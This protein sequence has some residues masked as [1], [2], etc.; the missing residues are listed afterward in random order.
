MTREE[1]LVQALHKSRELFQ[2]YG[3]L[4]MSKTPPQ[5][6][7]ALRNYTMVAII[8]RALMSESDLIPAPQIPE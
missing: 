1:N 4:H 7:K 3:D 2:Q 5:R 6:E 8:N